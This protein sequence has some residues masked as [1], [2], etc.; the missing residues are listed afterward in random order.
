MERQSSGLLWSAC[1]PQPELI[2]LYCVNPAEPRGSRLLSGRR[3]GRHRVEEEERVGAGGQRGTRQESVSFVN[4]MTFNLHDCEG[5]SHVTM[6]LSLALFEPTVC[7]GIPLHALKDKLT[8]KTD[9]PVIIDS[10]PCGWKVW[11]FVVQKT[12]LEF[13]SKI[14]LQRSHKQLQ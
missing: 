12:F 13:H 6:S 4:F 3:T 7:K 5:G 9:N 8:K 10:T 11:S 14:V 1:M 2:P